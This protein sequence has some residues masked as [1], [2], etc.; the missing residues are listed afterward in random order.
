MFDRSVKRPVQQLLMRQLGIAGLRQWVLEVIGWGRCVRVR[1]PANNPQAVATNPARPPR[2][3]YNLQLTT[4]TL[5]TPQLD[6][7]SCQLYL[8]RNTV[9]NVDLG[10]CVGRYEIFNNT[11]NVPLLSRAQF[12]A[13]YTRRT[14]DWVIQFGGHQRNVQ[15]GW[16]A[17]C[18]A[19]HGEKSLWGSIKLRCVCLDGL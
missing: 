10:R 18:K 1:Y 17:L 9:K 3:T 12:W 5:D 2:P 6:T 7:S 15:L 14:R 13:T 11:H 16:Y 8:K 4:K 19:G